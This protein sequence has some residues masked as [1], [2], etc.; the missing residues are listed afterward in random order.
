ML[1]LVRRR[2]TTKMNNGVCAPYTNEDVLKSLFDIGDLK[3][4]GPDGLHA[5]FSK[6]FDP[7]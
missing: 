4:P 6:R 7:C 3:A 1:S 2:V 5:I